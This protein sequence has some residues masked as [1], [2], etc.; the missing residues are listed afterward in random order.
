MGCG[1]GCIRG[2]IG[3]FTC[4]CQALD[5]SAVLKYLGTGERGDR[6]AGKG[7]QAPVGR[8]Q[9]MGRTGQAVSIARPPSQAGVA[10]P[11]P[12]FN[13]CH[14]LHPPLAPLGC[15][16]RPQPKKGKGPLAPLPVS[17]PSCPE[18]G[19]AAPGPANL[20]FVLALTHLRWPH[21]AGAI[22]ISITITL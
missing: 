14:P 17:L 2:C 4:P 16:A 11:G 5:Q 1:R 13:P 20:D 3:L 10:R 9:A 19:V 8:P 18:R 12:R 15:T 7:R 6:Q 21:R 22:T